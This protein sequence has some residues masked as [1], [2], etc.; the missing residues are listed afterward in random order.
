MIS[1]HDAI[2]WLQSQ[3]QAAASTE[4]LREL[5]L[6]REEQ[7]QTTDFIRTRGNR[8]GKRKWFAR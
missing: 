7:E 4:K 5:N 6:P 2:A 3:Q 8:R 1:K